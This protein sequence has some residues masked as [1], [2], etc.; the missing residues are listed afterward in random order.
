M[1]GVRKKKEQWLTIRTPLAA[2]F[3]SGQLPRHLSCDWLG[4][5]LPIIIFP[6]HIYEAIRRQRAIDSS[7]R[8]DQ[9]KPSEVA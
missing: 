5:S 8:S 6:E 4:A 9:E 3:E 2:I 1:D 7:S